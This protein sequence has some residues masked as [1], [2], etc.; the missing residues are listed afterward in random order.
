MANTAN[1]ASQKRKT[2]KPFDT[3]GTFIILRVDHL[4]VQT[5]VQM[6]ICIAN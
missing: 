3:L 1:I 5:K 6:S 2:L 4:Y